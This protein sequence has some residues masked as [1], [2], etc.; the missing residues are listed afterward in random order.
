MI[1]T[2][3]IKI[4]ADGADKSNMLEMYSKNYIQGLTTNPT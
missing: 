2:L 4:F 1:E 3:N